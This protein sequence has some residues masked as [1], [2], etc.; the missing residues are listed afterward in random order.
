MTEPK[1][2][3]DAGVKKFEGFE[4]PEQN[5]TQSPN[6][7]IDILPQ[8]ETVSEVKVIL[9]I[10][11]HTWGY[12]DT[13]KKI[14]L[15]EFE[16]GRKRKDGSRIDKGTGLTVPSIRDGLKRAQ[17][18]GFITVEID[19]R[20]KGRV[21]KFYSLTMKQD[22][23]SLHPDLETLAPPVQEVCNPTEKDTSERNLEKEK[24][25]GASAPTVTDTPDI[26]QN[27][28]QNAVTPEPEPKPGPEPEPQPITPFTFQSWVETIRDSANRPAVLRAMFVTLYGAGIPETDLPT[29]AYIGRAARTVG[30]ASRLAELLWQH[31]TRPPTGDVLAYLMAVAKNGGKGNGTYQQGNGNRQERGRWTAEDAKRINAQITTE[32]AAKEAAGG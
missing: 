22:A 21:K 3:Y 27:E 6:M 24:D 13:E 7:L 12:H 17:E 18:H 2:E 20:D 14:T 8:I 29:Y 15:D 28:P 23:N 26:S 31:S 19:D 9:Y 1:P 11:R 32:L 25:G 5:W 10:L 30:G 16:N 4:K